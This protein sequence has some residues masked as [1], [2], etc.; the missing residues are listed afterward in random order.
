MFTYLALVSP[1][2]ALAIDIFAR[3]L[4]EIGRAGGQ[5]VGTASHARERWVVPADYRRAA[6]DGALGCVRGRR[7]QIP[8]P[9]PHPT[10]LNGYRLSHSNATID[11]REEAASSRGQRG[12]VG[13]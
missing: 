12:S 6:G 3:S 11:R 8:S 13:G 1:P 10:P 9:N 4:A 7:V 2:V 5:P